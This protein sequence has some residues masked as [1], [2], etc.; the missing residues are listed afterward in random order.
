MTGGTIASGFREQKAA[1]K[2]ETTASLAEMLKTIFHEQEIEPFFLEPWGRPGLDSSEFSP[3]HWLELVKAIIQGV[4]TEAR[5]ILIL[6]GTDTMAYTS[7]WL[8]LCFAGIPLPVILTG[9]QLT[10][11]FSPEDGSVNLR[12]AAQVLNAGI[13]GVWIYFNWKLIPGSRAHKAR[14]VHPDAFIAANGIPLYFNPEWSR[15]RLGPSV[16]THWVPTPDL[17]KIL[18]LNP[19]EGLKVASSITWH[20]CTPGSPLLLSGSE[21]VLGLIGYGSGN[22]PSHE[23]LHIKDFFEGRRHPHILACS[24]AEG[25]TKNP[26]LYN[27]VGLASLSEFGFPIWSQMDYPIEF[28]HALAVFALLTHPQEPEMVFA[29][30]LKRIL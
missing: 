25:D 10:K 5:G 24:Q 21:S 23:L 30:H 1:P 7:A 3:K 28:V 16:P 8:S 17:K 22:M 29:R 19:D 6:H 27:K 26:S 2:E 15:H 9:S 14:A 18:E 11:D 12:G 20:F 4:Q 13:P